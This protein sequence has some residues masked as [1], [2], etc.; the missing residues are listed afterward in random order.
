LLTI[1]P[2]IKRVANIRPKL[3]L[4]CRIQLHQISQNSW[5]WNHDKIVMKKAK[6]KYIAFFR[7]ADDLWKP[8]KLAVQIRFYES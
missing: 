3:L 8:N 2:Q 6:V 1:V 5:R 7:R 4:D